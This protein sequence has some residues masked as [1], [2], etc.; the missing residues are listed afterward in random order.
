MLTIYTQT[1][2]CYLFGDHIKAGTS[3]PELIQISEI[4]T[5]AATFSIFVSPTVRVSRDPQRHLE[6]IR[7]QNEATAS[8]SFS[9]A[10][11]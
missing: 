6:K 8:C 3:V 9:P 5:I 11:P 4:T 1:T 2:I 7:I 10:P